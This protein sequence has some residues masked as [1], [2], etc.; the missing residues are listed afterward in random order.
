MADDLILNDK[1]APAALPDVCAPRLRVVDAIE[2]AV[3][4][5]RFVYVSAPAGSGKSVSALLWLR[6]AKLPA[7]WIGL[8]RF[9]DAPTVFFRQ[10]AIGLLSAQPGNVAMR[11]VLA[12]PA[13][14][15]R[16]SSIR[17]GC[18][19]RRS[20]SSAATLW[21]WTTRTSSRTARS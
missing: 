3:R 14:S 2:R 7:V 18:S 21:C 5:K 16:R 15:R 20:R 12:D 1:F 8:D 11:R 6:H 13:F 10:L 19:P 17:S 4:S 9:D